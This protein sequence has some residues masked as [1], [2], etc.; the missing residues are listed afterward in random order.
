MLEKTLKAFDSDD[1]L[2][3]CLSSD[4]VIIFKFHFLAQ[5]GLALLHN[6][7]LLEVCFKVI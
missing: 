5:P 1:S 6:H 3:V 4:S 2:L 7:W